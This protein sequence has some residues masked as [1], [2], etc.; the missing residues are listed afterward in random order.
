M[1]ISGVLTGF[2]AD[3]AYIDESIGQNKV[4]IWAVLQPSP[5]Q[6]VPHSSEINK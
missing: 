5:N 3:W 4:R 1:P 2:A 6:A